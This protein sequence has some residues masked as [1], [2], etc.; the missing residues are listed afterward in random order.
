MIN[1][2]QQKVIDSLPEDK[3]AFMEKQKNAFTDWM[4]GSYFMSNDGY[5]WRCK[6]DDIKYELE[7]GND[8]SKGVT[9]CHSC[10]SSYCD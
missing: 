10:H 2:Y 7:N 1:E 8:G 9:G 3:R 6:H 4:A 5:C